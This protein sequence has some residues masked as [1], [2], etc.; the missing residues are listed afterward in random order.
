M[1]FQ[2][3][4]P[5]SSCADHS[6]PVTVSGSPYQC[7]LSSGCEHHGAAGLGSAQ[8]PTPVPSWV[9]NGVE[10]GHP[11]PPQ[12]HRAARGG[13]PSRPEGAMACI[14]EVPREDLDVWTW[15][16]LQHTLLWPGLTLPRKERRGNLA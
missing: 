6:Y 1:G 9:S 12:R 3:L 8:S 14:L 7:H 5:L 2:T 11:S 15:L 13:R 16:W 10:P 4:W